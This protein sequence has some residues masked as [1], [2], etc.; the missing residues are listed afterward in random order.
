MKYQ[1]REIEILSKRTIFGKTIAEIRILASGQIIDVPFADLEE[2]CQTVSSHEIAFKAIAAKIRNEIFTQKMLAP[3]ESSIIPLPHQILAL[4][5]VMSGQFLRFLIADEVGMGKTIE[6]GLV[7]KELKLRGVVKRSLIIV[8]KSAMLQWKQEMKRHFN[9]TF[10]IYDTDYINTLTRTFSNLEADNEINI[11]VQHNQL[12]V[13]TDAL[14]PIESRQGWSKQKVEEYNRY[15]IQSVL[16]ADFDLLVI[17]ECHKVGGSDQ[18]IGRYQMAD[19][20]CNAIPNIL[21]LSATPHR[22]K[23]DHFRRV[24]QL[25]DADAFSGEGMPR[26]PELEPYVVRTEKRQAIDYNG[27]PLFKK[28]ITQKIEVVY[29]SV[30]H[31]KQQKL[32]KSVSKY[33]V[34]GFNLAQQTKNNSYGFVMILFQRMM[35]SSTQAILDAMQKRAGRLSGER[36][37]ITKENIIQNM[38]EYGYEG[39]LELDF[40]QKIFSF[41]EETQANYDTELSILQGLIRDAKDCL[42]T[43]ADVKVEFLL[44]KLSEL[45]RTENNPDVKFLIF[46]EF[47][48]TQCMLKKVLEEKGGYVCEVINGSMEF[49]QRMEALRNFKDKAQI[50]VSTDAAGESLNMQFAHIVI[51]FDMPWNPMIVEQRIGR[52][53]RIGQTHEVLAFNIL[54]DNSIDKR[55]YEVVETKLNKIMNEL[56]IDKTSDVLDSAIERDSINKLYLTSLLNPAKFEQESTSWLKE[57]R[58]K[59]MDYR[60][61]EGSLPLLNSHDIKVEKVESI[62]HSPIPKWLEGLTK[63]YLRT[64]GIAYQALLDGITFKFPGFKENIYTFNIKES[65]NNPI[66]EPLSLQ[67]EIIQNILSD[68]V[69]FTDSQIIPLV[70]LKQGKSTSGFWSIWH[71]QAKNQFESHHVIQPVFFSDEGD[72]FQAFAQDVW[73]KMIQDDNYLDCLG[74]LSAEESK[75]HFKNS[76]DKVEEILQVKYR[77][78]EEKIHANTGRIKLNKEKAFAFQEKQMQKIGIENI[79]QSRLKRL[80]KEKEQWMQNFEFSKQ[81]VPDLTC[82]LIIKII[83]G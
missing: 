1:G 68:A 46:T 77:E 27:K 10:H 39:Q 4:E 28:R 41:I 75:A 74:V 83:H 32:Y 64:K 54:L 16:E 69:P 48:S 18:Q 24:L 38:E 45:K 79:R 82:L 56:G 15:R 8:P 25:L 72:S 17:D 19:I 5:K 11:W 9:E 73:S 44:D 76:T 70:K 6:T 63:N 34:D 61:T 59:L 3:I 47:T 49:E 12:I 50:L 43:E 20:L 57:I 37:D 29:D 23:S 51:N 78:M 66:P 52:V 71:L 26:I 33:V 30:R 80:F 7:L 31:R 2:G 14:K 65:V 35:S 40:E 67:H 22:G 21:L 13:S 55:V 62:K 81:V 36:K 53:D 58:Q 60:S 42:N